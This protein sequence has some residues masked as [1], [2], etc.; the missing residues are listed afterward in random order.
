[1]RAERLYTIFRRTNH[2]HRLGLSVGVIDVQTGDPRTLDACVQAADATMYECK[3]R[4]KGL[5]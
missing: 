3:K 1:M 5:A 4:R 2:P